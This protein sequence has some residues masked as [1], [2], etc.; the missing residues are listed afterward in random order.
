MITRIKP[1]KNQ[2]EL[3]LISAIF[4]GCTSPNAIY[5]RTSELAESFIKLHHE[6]QSYFQAQQISLCDAPVN[7]FVGFIG[8]LQYGDQWFRVKVVNVD[9]YPDISVLLFDI[10]LSLNVNAGEIHHL[11]GGWKTYPKTL[12]CFSFSGVRPPS[13]TAWGPEA[14]E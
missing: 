5:L 1:I 4:V 2:E 14:T 10:A 12:L 6:L 8:A 13:G 3:T 7:L 9:K 11:P